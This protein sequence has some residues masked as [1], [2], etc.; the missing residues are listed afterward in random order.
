MRQ[1]DLILAAGRARSKK[2]NGKKNMKKSRRTHNTLRNPQQSGGRD[3][4]ET[5]RDK[6]RPTR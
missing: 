2:T 3:Y 1:G 4:L 6:T 5:A